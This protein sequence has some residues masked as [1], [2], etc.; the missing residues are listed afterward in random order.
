MASPLGPVYI[1]K[2]SVGMLPFG[3]AVSVVLCVHCVSW[4]PVSMA[5]GAMSAGGDAAILVMDFDGI[6]HGRSG[7]H[8]AAT[9]LIS[10]LCL[11]VPKHYGCRGQ[12]LIDIFYCVGLSYQGS[13]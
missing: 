8:L 2:N 6:W 3:Y 12:T 11:Y 9:G 1:L 7:C 10:S 13:C 4:N 5:L